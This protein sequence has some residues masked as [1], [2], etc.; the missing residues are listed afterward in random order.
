MKA[1][2]SI[3]DSFGKTLVLPLDEDDYIIGTAV[4][5]GELYV[6]TKKGRVWVTTAAPI[7]CF[8]LVEIT[9]IVRG[10]V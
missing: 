9:D 1:G 5:G 2:K 4:H 8:D 3:F 6:W 7:E 10:I